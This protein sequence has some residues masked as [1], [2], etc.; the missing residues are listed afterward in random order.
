MVRVATLQLTPPEVGNT[1]ANID[2]IRSLLRSQLASGGRTQHENI[3]LL[4]LPEM[5]TTGYRF[6]DPGVIQS[7]CEDVS[8]LQ[9]DSPSIVLGSEIAREMHAY[10]VLGF[11]ERR[12]ASPSSTMTEGGSRYTTSRPYDARSPPFY[13]SSSSSDKYEYFN[14]AALFDRTG[15][16]VHCFRKHFLYDDDKVWAQEGPGFEYVD[17]P[18][19]GRLCV[20]ICMD[21]NP[22][23]FKAPFESFELASF[24]RQHNVD[25]LA[26]PTA[27]LLSKDGSESQDEDEGEDQ[28]SGPEDPHMPTVEYWAWRCMPLYS[29]TSSPASST[30][31]RGRRTIFISANRTGTEQ[32]VTFAGSSSILQFDN[33][34]TSS[35]STQSSASSQSPASGSVKLLAAMGTE[36]QGLQ[37]VTV[38]LDWNPK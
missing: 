25:I 34:V 35:S 24:C 18:D 32:G 1:R 10:V 15:A 38:Q 20:G 4:V 37:S 5:I 14:S 30:Q 13:E 19:L 29:S 26:L 21:L 7:I 36:T 17:I 31:P 33:E 6:S 16:L 11:A 23:E 28:A 27:W 2:A 22:Y 9:E 3:D 8:Q 12:E